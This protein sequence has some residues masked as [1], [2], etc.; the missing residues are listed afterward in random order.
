[1]WSI[2]TPRTPKDLADGPPPPEEAD[3]ALARETFTQPRDEARQT[4]RAFHDRGS[5]PFGQ[6]VMAAVHFAQVK[7]AS[8]PNGIIT[9]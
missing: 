3:D 1:M 5:S 9:R 7:A 8:W 2:A 6:L 4:A